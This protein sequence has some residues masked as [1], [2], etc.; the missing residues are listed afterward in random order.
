MNKRQAKKRI[1]KKYNLVKWPKGAIPRYADNFLSALFRTMED[2]IKKGIGFDEWH[3]AIVR[4]LE[5]DE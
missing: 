2:A 5:G 3:D 4:G 1:K